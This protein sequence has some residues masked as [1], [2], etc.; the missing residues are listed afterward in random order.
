MF[1]LKRS[2]DFRI[3]EFSNTEQSELELK[4]KIQKLFDEAKQKW[5]G[6]FDG[7]SQI[8]LLPSHHSV[9]AFLQKIEEN[10]EIVKE[11]RTPVLLSELITAEMVISVIRGIPK[12]QDRTAQNI[13]PMLGIS[14]VSCK[15]LLDE[16]AQKEDVIELRTTVTTAYCVVADGRKICCGTKSC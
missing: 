10:V 11:D 1:L 3:L 14:V 9:D 5:P 2:S 15:K 12:Q 13:G 4:K 7:T 6:V 16:M 8:Q